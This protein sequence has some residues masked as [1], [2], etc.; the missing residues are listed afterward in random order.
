MDKI[1]AYDALP[2]AEGLFPPLFQ[3]V[4]LDIPYRAYG[5]L[6]D[7]TVEQINAAY[8][9]ATW[10]IKEAN[11]DIANI[12]SELVE[13][14]ESGRDIVSF[15]MPRLLALHMGRFDISGQEAFPDAQWSEYFAAMAIG[16][17]VDTME[18]AIS[19]LEAAHDTAREA[20][21]SRLGGATLFLLDA[22]EALIMAEQLR[23]R[24][25]VRRETVAATE[26]RHKDQ[27]S[28]QRQRAAIQSHAKTTAIKRECILYYLENSHLSQREAARRFYE[29]LPVEQ[30]REFSP[31]NAVRTLESAIRDY[32]KDRL[33][34]YVAEGLPPVSGEGDA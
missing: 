1:P 14:D 11:D 18:R 31:N 16:R 4:L 32:L 24:E 13:Q 12:A 2:N 30:K 6:K 23:Q 19:S 20:Q 3:D 25:T 7:R 28:L 27:I 34:P 10:M 21:F 5:L 29:T 17:Y 33:P 8:E 26:E 9:A 15:R 22:T